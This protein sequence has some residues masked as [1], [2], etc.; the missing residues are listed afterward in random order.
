MLTQPPRNAQGQVLPH[1]HVEI[2]GDDTV[3]RLISAEWQTLDPKYPEGKRLSS[4]AW[5]RS[6]EPN[7]GL[8]VNLQSLILNDNLSPAEFRGGL[9]YPASILMGVCSDESE[10]KE[11][12]SEGLLG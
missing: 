6:S 2:S 3:I 12:V 1:D 5:E 10:T 4:M 11:A 7:G 8:S 9:N